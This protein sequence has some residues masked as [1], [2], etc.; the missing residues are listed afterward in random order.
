MHSLVESV[1]GHRLTLGATLLAP[2]PRLAPG[3][4]PALPG[5]DPNFPLGTAAVFHLPFAL[6]L[7]PVLFGKVHSLAWLLVATGCVVALLKPVVG[8]AVAA[9]AATALWGIPAVV[10]GGMISGEEAP[11]AGLLLLGLL[12]LRAAATDG[13]AGPRAPARVVGAAMLFGSATLFRL[14]ALVFLPGFVLAAALL[15]GAPG[16]LAAAVGASVVPA[17]HAVASWLVHGQ[18][19]GFAQRARDVSA[20]RMDPGTLAP[21]GDLILLLQGQ[22]GPLALGIAAVGAAL[23]LKHRDPWLRALSAQTAVAAALLA[24][25]VGLGFLDPRIVRYFVPLLM[26][27]GPAAVVGAAAAVG[28]RHPEHA[29]AAAMGMLLTIA[30][31][32]L[33]GAKRAT[34]EV[35]YPAGLRAAGVWIAWNAGEQRIV[36]NRWAAEAALLARVPS[37]RFH[38]LRTPEN[39]FPDALPPADQI[40]P[41]GDV[42]LMTAGRE[43]AGV[44]ALWQRL[45]AGQELLFARGDVRIWGTRGDAA[46]PPGA[47][48]WREPGAQAPSVAVCLVTA[49][50]DPRAA[51]VQE[52][53]QLAVEELLDPA[54]PRRAV[55]LVVADTGGTIAGIP[56]ALALCGAERT[57]AVIGPALPELAIPLVPAAA[58]H[59]W[60]VVVPRFGVGDPGTLPPALVTV[61]GSPA[62]MGEAAATDALAQGRTRAAVL[63]RQGPRGAR[64]EEAFRRRLEAGGGAVVAVPPI[65]GPEA[66]AWTEA[67]A[68]LPPGVDALFAIGAPAEIAA[69]TAGLRST[70]HLWLTEEAMGPEILQGTAP[71]T[72]ARIH[73]V[74]TPSPE[75][76]FALRFADRFGR[77]PGPGAALGYDAAAL[78]LEAVRSAPDPSTDAL[79]AA[80][81]GGRG[82]AFGPGRLVIDDGV[83]R[84]DSSRPTVFDVAIGP[85]GGPEFVARP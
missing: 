22:I 38:T 43:D 12:A 19:L 58:L 44:R 3:P 78:A 48:P 11:C 33:I 2:D 42:L 16:G 36:V 50:S 39:G 83:P 57:R 5:L 61:G 10:R 75:P 51:D 77:R 63:S 21:I 34:E 18:P 59:D 49:T 54:D 46:H 73:G 4:V 81:E 30:G 45:D 64:A 52:G 23:G 17:G 29:V 71:A 70:T 85:G 8:P 65:E 66:E 31:P 84:L 79:R 14:D 74:A 68:A 6:G 37:W 28:R 62:A 32:G 15:R 76:R 20:A 69:V 1:A 72:W 26:L 60:L 7:D 47:L 40:E 55:R 24:G 41:L 13:P 9:L 56:A 82:T 27:L 53:I 35:R 67:L 80:V 25:V